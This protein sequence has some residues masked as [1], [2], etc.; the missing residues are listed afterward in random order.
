[1]PTKPKVRDAGDRCL[2]CGESTAPGSGRFVNR[3]GASW[4]PSGTHESIIRDLGLASIYLGYYCPE[5]QIADCAG[6]QLEASGKTFVPR[7][8]VGRTGELC[9]EHTTDVFALPEEE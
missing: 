5:C 9:D 1:M 6:C 3:I 7:D 4:G 8:F 2:R